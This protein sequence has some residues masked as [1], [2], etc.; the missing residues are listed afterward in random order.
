METPG[1]MAAQQLNMPDCAAACETYKELAQA[2]ENCQFEM[3]I[4]LVYDIHTRAFTGMEALARWRHP[5][6]GTLTPANFLTD[7]Y[8]CGLVDQ[9]DFYMLEKACRLLEAWNHSSLAN[10]HI[11][12]NFSRL[13]ISAPDFKARFDEIVNKYD[14]DHGNLIL[15]ITED[16]LAND[17]ATAHRN[18]AE[19]TA[20]GFRAAL[21]DMGAGF[22][23]FLDLC[24][25]P[26]DR[27]KID[28]AIIK[29]CTTPRGRAVLT[30]ITQLAHNLGMKVLCEGVENDEEREVV[31]ECGCDYIQGFYYSHVLPVDKAM[32]QYRQSRGEEK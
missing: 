18:I 1:S 31:E 15:E 25:Y 21:D 30:E 2:L 22:T 26:V 9:L 29:R 28:R 14:F 11:S 16:S 3:Y 17:A 6:R 12:C 7:L 23:S 24:D 19:C 5:E 27:I 20:C 13:S 4:Q 10:L 8:S 32:E